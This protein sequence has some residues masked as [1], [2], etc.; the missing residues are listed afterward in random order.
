VASLLPDRFWKAMSSAITA[1]RGLGAGGDRPLRRTRRDRP[2]GAGSET[3]KVGWMQVIRWVLI[4]LLGPSLT[5]LAYAD[6]PEDGADAKPG[7]ERFL[8]NEYYKVS[9]DLRTRMELANFE[10]RSE[11]SQAYMTR[12]RAGI[13]SKPFH[14]LTGYAELE[15][16]FAYDN[17][18]YWDGTSSNSSDQ[19]QISDP[20]KTDLNQLFARYENPELLGLG[21]TVGRQRIALDDQ[22]F[23]GNVGWRQN[24]QT[25]DAGLGSTS[26]GLEGLE[27]RYGYLRK[28]HRIFGNKGG[29]GTRDW[30]SD[31]HLINL[32]YEGFEPLAVTG[33]VYLFDFKSDS[34]GNSSNSYGLRVQGSTQISDSW[35]ASYAASYAWQEDTGR[36]PENYE[37][38]YVAA[39]GSVAYEPLGAFGTGYELLGSDSGNARFVTPLATAHKFNGF[40]DVFLNN[41]GVNGLQDL[42]AY[43]A[44]KLPWKLK[45]R[46]I[47]HHFWSDENGTALGEE[48][49]FLI[50]RPIN[51]HL[52]V[53]TKGALFE[54]KTRSL[55]DGWRYWLEF[56]FKY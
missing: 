28:I 17:A 46:F 38:D 33:F 3:T 15:S 29:A 56:T 9:L 14:G 11:S 37:A 26:F 44:P 18:R 19:T 49:D 45:G 10:D 50:S 24:E 53:L 25:F 35:R 6:E 43:I 30:D 42:Y 21:A 2:T 31:S 1:S 27:L 36:N 51:R 48:Y 7:W 16:S 34:A 55:A 40:A 8:D 20:R 32:S 23:V 41:G 12:L 13:G 39:D 22:R 5:Q 54:S 4:L 47:Y 52:S